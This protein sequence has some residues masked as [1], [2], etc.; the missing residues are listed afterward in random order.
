M[1]AQVN[2]GP[3]IEISVGLLSQYSNVEYARNQELQ[4]HL[5]FGGVYLSLIF[6]KCVDSRESTSVYIF[7]Y[8]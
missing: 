6:A 1:Y 2:I 4:I 7:S 3:N 8:C 5:P